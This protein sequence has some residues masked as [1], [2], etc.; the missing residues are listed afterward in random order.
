MK[1]LR[2]FILGIGLLILGTGYSQT[3]PLENFMSDMKDAPGFYFMNLETNL[4][5]SGDKEAGQTDHT[6]VIN[7]KVF[8]FD[9]KENGNFSAKNI[10]NDFFSKVNRNDYK[11][12]IEVKSSGDHVEMMVKEEGDRISQFIMTIREEDETTIIAAS[13]NF[14]LKDLSKLG[15]L[16]NSKSFE[17]LQTLSEE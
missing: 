4:V 13:G 7:L 12:L 2:I 14:D 17:I 1:Q 16:K 8:S 11:G 10:Y 9:Q 6:K 3:N 15:A 5:V